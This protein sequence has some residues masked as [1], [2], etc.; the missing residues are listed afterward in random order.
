MTTRDE[1]FMQ[2][3]LEQAQQAALHDEVPVGAVVVLNDEIIARASNQPI[4]SCD[5]TAHAEVAALRAAAHVLGNYRLVECELF[6]TLEPCMMCAGAIVHS[7]VK[8]LVYGAI[9]PKA[10][11]VSSNMELLSAEFLNHRLDIEGGVLA[12]QCGALISEFF[13]LRRAKKRQLRQATKPRN[14]G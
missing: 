6:V 12:Q 1:Q 2:A 9:E 3:A 4:T 8:R 14:P 13:Q 7:R 11:V 10:G 5:P